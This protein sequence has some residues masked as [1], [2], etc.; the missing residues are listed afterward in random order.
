MIGR[1]FGVPCSNGRRTARATSYDNDPVLQ[2]STVNPCLRS[3]NSVDVR[4]THRPGA[5]F[6]ARRYRAATFRATEAA[7]V[8]TAR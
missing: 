8:S 5:L 6:A 3:R 2:R 4:R 7:F 1:G